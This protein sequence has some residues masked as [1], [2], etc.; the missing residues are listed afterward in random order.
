MRLWI[1]AILLLLT[2]QL[3]KL[4]IIN[5]MQLGESKPVISGFF[6]ITYVR[7]Q[8]AAF[9]MLEGKTW[10]FIV[11]AAII[12]AVLLYYNMRYKLEPL[13]QITMGIIIGGALGNLID[14]IYYG[15]VID[16]FSIS[17][18]PIFNIADIAICTGGALVM[19]YLLKSEKREDK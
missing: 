2:D 19:V 11:M 15:S 10:F 1:A 18:W 4:F 5:T 9:S 16:F 6:N 12:V 17:W 7:N 8:G 14:R 3:S 13:L